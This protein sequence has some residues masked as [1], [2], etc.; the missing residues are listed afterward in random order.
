MSR[1]YVVIGV[2]LALGT[3]AYSAAPTVG[4]EEGATLGLR[5]EECPGPG[6]RI[7]YTCHIRVLFENNER[8]VDT[9]TAGIFAECDCPVPWG[10]GTELDDCHSCGY[11]NWGVD[12]LYGAIHDTTQFKGW[13]DGEWNS[14]T[15]CSGAYEFNNGYNSQRQSNWPDEPHQWAGGWFD[16]QLEGGEGAGCEALDGNDFNF[17][18]VYME[19]Y[20]LDAFSHDYLTTLT[21]PNLVVPLD[22]PD[23]DTCTGQSDWKWPTD[24]GDLDVNAKVRARVTGSYFS[25]Q[26]IDM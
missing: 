24:Q 11:G 6:E 25:A 4:S 23:E 26:C 8:T 16:W 9:H 10:C 20:E 12:S 7:I 17:G 5:Q 13:R 2:L 18:N 14:C 22:C 15:C 1:K 3:Y 21:Y 19:L